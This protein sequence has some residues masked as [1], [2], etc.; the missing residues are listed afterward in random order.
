[1]W[2]KIAAWVLLSLPLAWLAIAIAADLQSPGAMLGA[3]PGEAVLLHLGQWGIRILLLALSVSTIRRRLGYAPVLKVRRLIG[4]FAFAYLALHFL[5]YL[6]FFTEFDWAL[7][8]EELA[9]RPYIS[10]GFA[11]LCILCAL[12]A[13][14]TRGWQRRLRRGWKRLHRLAH[15]AAALGLLHLWW[16]TKDGYGEVV[17]YGVW[18]AALYADRLLA[19]RKGRRSA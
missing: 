2:L 10:V 15:V 11:A 8:L 16:L 9:Q 13:T 1:M 14:S 4:L 19:S 5:F 6:W 7:I 12:A 18:L 3:D 17:L